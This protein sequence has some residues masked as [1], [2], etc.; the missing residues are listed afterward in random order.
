MNDNAVSVV[1]PTFNRAH[2]IYDTIPTYIQEYVSEV[3]VIDDNSEDNTT[4]V[5]EKLQISF[6]II[7]YVKS[8]VKIRQTGAKNIG[9]RLAKGTYIYFGDD[10]SILKP[11]SIKSLVSVANEN[12]DAII[13]VRH[14][15]MKE[16]DDLNKILIDDKYRTDN[17]ALFYNSKNLKLDLCFSFTRILEIPFCQACMLAPTSIAKANSFNTRF[18]GT[19]YRE[20]TDFIMQI[21]SKGHK[22]YLD[23]YSLQVNLPKSQASGGVRSVNVIYRHFSEV[24]NEYMFYKRNKEYIKTI[25]EINVNP[26]LRALMHLVKKLVK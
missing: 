17:E 6:P 3:I 11:G 18:L 12:R 4:A 2:L 16:K 7:K 20:E 5:I 13:A 21:A 25:S 23:N 8:D 22:V 15:Y 24:I 9:I 26:F 14:I 19:C 1:I 10:D